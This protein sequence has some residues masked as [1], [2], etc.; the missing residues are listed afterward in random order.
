[1]SLETQR[2]QSS[3]SAS[4]LPTATNTLLDI[5]EFHRLLYATLQNPIGTV[6]AFFPQDYLPTMFWGKSFTP[7]IDIPDLSGRVYLVTGG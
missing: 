2:P 4:H 6:Q 1:M 7:E 3:S 5:L